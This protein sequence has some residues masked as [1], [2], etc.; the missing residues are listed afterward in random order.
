MVFAFFECP[1]AEY[2]QSTCGTCVEK[3]ICWFVVFIEAIAQEENEWMSFLKK[4]HHDLLFL[5]GNKR[6]NHHNLFASHQHPV[7]HIVA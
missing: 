3:G 4:H 1:R 5:W 7:V 2:Q 6:R